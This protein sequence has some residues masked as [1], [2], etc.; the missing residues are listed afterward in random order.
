MCNN[1]TAGA[2]QDRCL[3]SD[4]GG[5]PPAACCLDEQVRGNIGALLFILYSIIS[6]N[7]PAGGTDSSLYLQMQSPVPVA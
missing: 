4:L 2:E 7:G 3:R 6:S 1:V 5:S